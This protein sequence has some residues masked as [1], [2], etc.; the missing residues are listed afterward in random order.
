MINQVILHGR[1]TR[2]PELRHTRAGTPVAGFSLAVDRNFK[3][4]DGKKLTD[5]FDVVV[6]NQLGELC[7]RYLRKGD[8]VAVCG[9][10]QGRDWTDRDGARRR[11]IE[12]IADQVDFPP[13][14]TRAEPSA[15]GGETVTTSTHTTSSDLDREISTLLED[16]S[17]EKLPF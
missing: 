3:S 17:E 14:S 6:W 2:D 12:V 16:T 5:F 15:P 10:L 4:E 13:R 7:A 1:L 8:L 9:R 11:A